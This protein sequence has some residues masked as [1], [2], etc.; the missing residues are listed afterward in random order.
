MDEELDLA[1]DHDEE[2][3]G[4][5]PPRVDAPGADGDGRPGAAPADEVDT[6]L[7]EDL[8]AL[9]ERLAEQ[10]RAAAEANDRFIR[11]LAD[12][13]NYRKRQTTLIEDTRRFANE[14]LIGDLLPILDNFERAIEANASQPNADALVEG[15]R[16][17]HRQLSDTLRKAGLEP[18]EAVGQP[19]DPTVHEAIMEVPPA[20]G[21]EPHHVVEELRKGYKLNGR[22]LRASLVKVTGG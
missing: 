2:R 11:T 12:F 1:N 7:N 15:V 10:E 5:Q 17:I 16:L 3:T 18:I 4:S 21:Q 20:E 14:I 6:Q 9:K 13:D 19:F 8:A 22:V